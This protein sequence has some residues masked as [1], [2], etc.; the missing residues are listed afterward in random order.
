[1]LLV[2]DG[3]GLVPGRL[4]HASPPASRMVPARW[5]GKR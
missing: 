5:E 3:P 4:A 2:P 1:M